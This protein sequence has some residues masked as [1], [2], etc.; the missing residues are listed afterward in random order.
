MLNFINNFIKKLTKI[1]NK[2]SVASIL[3]VL[4]V[5]FL[6]FITL[7]KYA[8]SRQNY[9]VTEGYQQNDNFIYKTNIDLY[10][11]FYSEIYD[12][13]VFN[14]LKDDYE[15]GQIINK[16][17]ATSRSKILD[18]G[19][20]TGHHVAKLYDS[21]LDVIGLDISPSMIKKAKEN[22]PN[23]KFK[24][25]NALNE[26]EFDGN[27]FTHILALYFT[28]YYIKN[29]DLFFTNCYNWLMPG[30]TL[31][32]HVVDKEK[33]DP[34][35]PPGNP[36][37]IVSPQKYAEERITKTKIHFN[38]FEYNSNFNYDNNS[39]LAIFDEKFKFKNGKIRKQEHKLYMEN[40]NDILTMAQNAG[41]IIQGKIDL[42]HCAYENQFLFILTKPN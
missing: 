7:F 23:C 26:T 11:D 4:S 29:K 36:L 25:G 28:I 9:M 19:C 41:F 24:L 1:Y 38:D 5:V 34:I 3:L 18:I 39:N 15:I 30:G 40:I 6:I 22:Y 8:N 13:L 31:V 35:L 2:L 16:T 14:G 32:I 17:N 37:Y 42:V 10:D 21:K 20:G 33:F 12:H 27:N